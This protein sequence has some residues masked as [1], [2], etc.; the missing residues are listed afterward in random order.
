MNHLAN[1]VRQAFRL[2]NKF[3][4]SEPQGAGNLKL[5]LQLEIRASRNSKELL[6]LTRA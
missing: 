6:K 5:S 2:V 4:I 1:L 3:R